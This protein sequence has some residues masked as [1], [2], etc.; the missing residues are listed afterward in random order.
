MILKWKVNSINVICYRA[1]SNSLLLKLE[2]VSIENEES[3]GPDAV[4]WLKNEKQKYLPSYVD[5]SQTLDPKVL[6]K[7]SVDLNLKLMRWRI[8]PDLDLDKIQLTKCLLLGAGTL[9]CNVARSLLV[10]NISETLIIKYLQNL[11][12]PGLGCSSY[13]IRRFRESFLL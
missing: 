7:N 6:A 2:F 5:L 9:G 11:F 1:K 10:S 13:N 8:L 3:T 4:G 12:I